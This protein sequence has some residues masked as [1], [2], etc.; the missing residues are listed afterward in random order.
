[1]APATPEQKA[2]LSKLSPEQVKATELAGGRIVSMLTKAPGNE[3]SIGGLKVVT[4]NGWFA[5]RPSGTEDVYKLYAESFQ[6]KEHLKRIQEEAQALVARAL[7]S[8][9]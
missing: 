1:D 7:A 6:G 9:K 4:D 8:Q 3:A 2:V 5:A